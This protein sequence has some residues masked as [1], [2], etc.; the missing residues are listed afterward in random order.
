MES[1]EVVVK[2]Y[3]VGQLAGV[4]LAEGNW[5]KKGLTAVGTLCGWSCVDLWF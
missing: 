2:A 5:T 4:E 1:P 3:R